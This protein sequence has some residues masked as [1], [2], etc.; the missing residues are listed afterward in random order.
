MLRFKFRYRKCFFNILILA[1]IVYILIFIDLTNVDENN[2]NLAN[3]DQVEFSNLKLFPQ[4]YQDI[5][6]NE[7]SVYNNNVNITCLNRLNNDIKL[8]SFELKNDCNQCLIFNKKNE[9]IVNY[10]TFWQLKDF[11]KDNDD[12]YYRIL[13]LNIMSYLA[14]QNLCCTRFILWKLA[15]FP[16]E[17]ETELNNM[18]KYYIEKKI[19]QIKLFDIDEICSN[20]GSLFRKTVIC[21][22]CKKMNLN[23]GK[24]V[25]ISDLVR[26]MVLDIYPGIYIDGDVI[27]LRDLQPLWNINFAYRWSY[28][29]NIN[30]AVL[31]INKLLNPKIIDLYTDLMYLLIPNSFL[32][33]IIIFFIEMIDMNILA[34]V[35]H[36]YVVSYKMKRLSQS[37]DV[38]NYKELT[39]LNSILFDP[40][41]LCYDSQIK[42]LNSYSVCNFDEFTSKSFSNINQDNFIKHFFQGAFAYHI[43]MRKTKQIVENS[44]F[45]LLEKHYFNLTNK[46][47]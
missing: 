21:K 6:L 28:T 39:V 29:G 16:I 38:F 32:K 43:H 33:Y 11:N 37:S 20:R 19:I 12:Y 25:A 40:S 42:P 15:N 14:T 10:H 46:T 5:L 1:L 44:Y 47:I 30:T 41:W 18:F 2:Q 45:D 22:K 13:K 9:F 3:L 8:N 23:A 24:L 35:F 17:I 36:P 26:F 7:C 4:L 34:N 27:L 31:G